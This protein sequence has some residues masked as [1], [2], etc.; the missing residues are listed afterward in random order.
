M[1]NPAGPHLSYSCCLQEPLV[2]CS[3]RVKVLV[4]CFTCGFTSSAITGS[5]FAP[6]TLKMWS[7]A[8]ETLCIASICRNFMTLWRVMQSVLV[9]Q[10][11]AQHSLVLGG[12][13]LMYSWADI[14][15]HRRMTDTQPIGY[16]FWHLDV[17]VCKI[18]VR[19]DMFQSPSDKYWYLLLG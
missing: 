17:T 9:M 13:W 15:I 6:R 10:C 8:A 11:S 5:S 14:S 2:C 7:G 16:L 3:F 1:R 18:N 12:A 19:N 4:L